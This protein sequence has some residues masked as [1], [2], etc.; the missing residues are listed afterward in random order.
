M[1][2]DDLR[3]VLGLPRNRVRVVKPHVGGAFGH[4]EGLHPHE[5]LA[6]L[7]AM[8]TGRPVRFVLSRQEEF[9]A[10]WSR[11]IQVRDAQVA[12]RSDG[13]ILAWR[14][15]IVQDCGAYASI[16]PSVLSLSE[17]VTVGPYRTPALDIEGLVVYTNKPPAGAFRGFGNP[18]ATFTRELM[19]DICAR[20]LGLAPEELR[21]RNLIEAPAETANGLRLDTLP[22]RECTELVERAVDLPALRA[23]RRPFRGVGVANMIEW[24]GG[25]RWHTAFDADMSSVTIDVDADGSVTV[26]TDAADSGQGHTTLFTQI[27]CDLLG[28]SPDAVRVVL[29]DTDATPWGLGTFGSRTAVIQGSA[30]AR[31]CDEVRERMSRVAAHM[32]EAAPGD[33]E[34]R[35]GRISVKGTDRGVGFADVAAVMHYDRASLPPGMEPTALVAT[36]SF[37][38]ASE[39][40]DADGHGNFSGNYTC[41]STIAVVDVDP[42][43]GRV[44][45]VDWASAEDVGRALNPDIVTTQIQGGI[46]QGIGYALGEE[47]IL[48]EAGTVM[49]A[50]MVDYQVPT[51]PT[52]PLIEEKL[53]HVESRDPAHPL[54]QKGIGES[55]ITPPAAAIAC[56]VYDAIGVPIT[57]LPITPEK[58]LAAIASRA[59]AGA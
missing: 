25:C 1:L 20:R 47:L 8:R 35:R 54:G 28:V 38:G 39:V 50:S 21:R 9:S 26:R 44:T 36:A 57:S 42:E 56:A 16:S 18:Q 19:L 23:E 10:T 58:V 52:I 46:A 3:H 4:K 31:A 12:L 55:G 24:G 27:C 6:A 5:A 59:T 51:C 17:W 41:S 48:D 7:G 34:F 2:R 32:M 13:T 29:A 45:I 49:N 33:L 22:I 11:N 53:F 40:P 14:E 15:R 30:A 43:T 37:D